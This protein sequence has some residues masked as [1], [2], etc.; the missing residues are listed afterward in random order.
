MH[1]ECQNGKSRRYWEEPAE[2][3]KNAWQNFLQGFPQK[4]EHTTVAISSGEM[5]ELRS[6][7]SAISCG[8]LRSEHMTQIFARVLVPLR[9]S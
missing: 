1:R 8:L 6:H 9:I 7:T 3:V 5:L 4:A 2:K